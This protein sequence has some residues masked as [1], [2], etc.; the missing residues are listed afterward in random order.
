[1]NFSSHKIFQTLN[2]KRIFDLVIICISK[3]NNETWTCAEKKNSNG[4]KMPEKIQKTNQML[5]R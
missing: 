5:A 1:M 2:I 3:K 4:Q